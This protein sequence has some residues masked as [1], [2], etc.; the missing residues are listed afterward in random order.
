MFNGGFEEL[1]DIIKNFFKALGHLS[2]ILLKTII[3]WSFALLPLVVGGVIAI[4][5]SSML[6]VGVSFIVTIIWALVLIY[7]ESYNR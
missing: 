5:K 2:L 6:I 4:V 3:F 7:A 1:F